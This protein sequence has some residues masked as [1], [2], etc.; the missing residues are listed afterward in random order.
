MAS[1]HGPASLTWPEAIAPQERYLERLRADLRRMIAAG[2]PI[3]AAAAEA[4]LSERDAW[5]LFEDFNGRNATA[6]FKELEWE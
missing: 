3:S 6:G 2:R 5:A 4:G 1:G